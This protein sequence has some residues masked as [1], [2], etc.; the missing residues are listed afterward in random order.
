MSHFQDMSKGVINLKDIA[1]FAL[2]SGFS[3]FAT[4]RILESKKWR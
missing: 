1:Y 2:F 4:L 3:L